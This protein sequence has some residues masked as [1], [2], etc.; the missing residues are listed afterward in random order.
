LFDFIT[1]GTAK[2]QLFLLIL[3][4]TTGLFIAAP[5]LGHNSIPRMVK[6]GTVVT[7]SLILVTVMTDV[8]V[9][10]VSSLAELA[11]IAFKE[12]LVG[13][14]IGF[15]FMLIFLGVQGAGSIAGY[16]IGLHVANVFDPST[17]AQSS[18]IGQFW[19]LLA[20]LIFMSINGHHLLIRAFTD[21]YVMIPPG[22]VE[23][24]GSVGEMMIKY[25]AYLLVLTLKVVAPVMV[26][27]FLTDVSL[28]VLARMMPT[29]NV[30]F[31]GIP[32]KLGAGM[33][34]L[35]LS[36]PVLGFV[37]EKS[38]GY[39]DAELHRLFVLMGKA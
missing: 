11:A 9:P 10:E 24:Q 26:T 15:V 31:V 13:L 28:G 36:L 18:L 22:M 12:L 25:T 30:F 16:Q 38:I 39:M 14:I 20:F 19:L 1:F 34:V 17:Q 3:I 23:M 29:M 21:S 4:R 6:A 8:T 27:L 7:L 37:L 32:L 2:L 35:A 5:I 33:A